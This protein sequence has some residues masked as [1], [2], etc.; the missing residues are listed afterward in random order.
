MIII[1]IMREDRI[2]HI[3]GEII[4]RLAKVGKKKG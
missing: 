2:L 3:S 4:I 1:S